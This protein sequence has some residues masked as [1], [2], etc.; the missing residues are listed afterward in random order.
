[1]SYH[2]LTLLSAHSLS[3]SNFPETA[4]DIVYE[5]PEALHVAVHGTVQLYPEVQFCGM[6]PGM[7]QL[8]KEGHVVA[9]KYP[10]PYCDLNGHTTIVGVSKT[11]SGAILCHL[12]PFQIKRSKELL[13]LYGKLLPHNVEAPILHYL[14]EGLD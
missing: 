9:D 10:C 5:F 2:V 8:T 1:M 3:N 6:L 14:Y 7:D 11:Y 13:A 4:R 12:L